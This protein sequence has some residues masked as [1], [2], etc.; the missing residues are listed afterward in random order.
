MINNIPAGFHG[1]YVRGYQLFDYDYVAADEK[2]NPLSIG[3]F[4]CKGTED[5]QAVGQKGEGEVIGLLPWQGY[6]GYSCGRNGEIAPGTRLMIDIGTDC[7]YAI[8][9]EDGAACEKGDYIGIKKDDG[10][11][12]FNSDPT[13]VST[14]DY[15]P[16][17]YRVLSKHDLIAH[18]KRGK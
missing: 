18:I 6:I 14:G 1:S 11:L 16:T 13:Q 8:S 9:I 2:A 15:K 10:S 12:A 5:L 3:S 7:V 4:A 17:G